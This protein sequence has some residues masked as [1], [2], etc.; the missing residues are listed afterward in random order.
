MAVRGHGARIGALA[1]AGAAVRLRRHISPLA[2][3]AGQETVRAADPPTSRAQ[4]V[5]AGVGAA[6]PEP[7]GANSGADAP[8]AAASL[9]QDW[10]QL[11]SSAAAPR[12]GPATVPQP[13]AGAPQAAGGARAAPTPPP[14][15]CCAF[16]CR[17]PLPILA[18]GRG[19]V[20][21]VVKFERRYGACRRHMEDA[22]VDVGDGPQRYCQAR[23]RFL[24]CVSGDNAGNCLCNST[25]ST[26][27]RPTDALSARAALRQAAGA[28][29]VHGACARAVALAGRRGSGPALGHK[30]V[31]KTPPFLLR[32][33]CRA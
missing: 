32:W 2:C 10:D 23:P 4:E 12:Q 13:P 15:L 14:R 5:D 28:P 27:A 11:A 25:P 17:L 19:R 30:R 18:G 33:L 26:R 29:R 22:E 7:A 6:A 31:I 20:S 21:A 24:I 3:F 9:P 1:R 8:W 16:G